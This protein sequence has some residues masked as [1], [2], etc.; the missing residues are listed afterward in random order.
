MYIWSRILVLSFCNILITQWKHYVNSFN[1]YFCIKP[2]KTS[3]RVLGFSMSPC[4]ILFYT[5]LYMFDKLFP[6][7]IIY[8][9]PFNYATYP[10]F[11]PSSLCSKYLSVL[12]YNVGVAFL[13]LL[14]QSMDYLISHISLLFLRFA[15]LTTK[16]FC[17]SIWIFEPPNS[18]TFH[19]P[20]HCSLT[21]YL[22]V[23]LLFDKTFV[24]ESVIRHFYRVDCD[25]LR[26]RQKVNSR[27]SINDN[28]V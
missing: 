18:T 4:V 6:S 20:N 23:S 14:S 16:Y 11:E 24:F 3:L 27:P 12:G 2:T 1:R 25:F 19:I 17:D 9:T 13:N 22:T 26:K 10:C 5:I 15:I 21:N 28:Y 8:D 7:E